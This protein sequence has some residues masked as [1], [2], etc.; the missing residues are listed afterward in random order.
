MDT[1]VPRNQ[2]FSYTMLTDERIKLTGT[3][4]GKTSVLVLPY[5]TLEVARTLNKELN[6]EIKRIEDY[7]AKNGIPYCDYTKTG[8]STEEPKVRF[9]RAVKKIISLQKIERGT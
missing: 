6:T 3:A 1:L 2:L 7:L 5:E 9:R 4:I 8:P